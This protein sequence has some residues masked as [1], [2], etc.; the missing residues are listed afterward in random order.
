M[1]IYIIRTIGGKEEVIAEMIA[2]KAISEN[3]QIYSAFKIEELKGYVFVE[4]E[5][6][7]VMKVVKEIP[8]IRNV[9]K[10]TITLEELSKYIKKEEKEE[11]KLEVNDIVEI[12]G[13]PF[14]GLRG[15]VIKVDE[16]KKEVTV[17]LL[18]VAVSLP[19][20][21]SLELVRIVEKAKK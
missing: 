2:N 13:G 19:V 5:E 1:P 8:Y 4:G 20:T 7:D 10:Q 3:L 15:K 12:I 9:V 16:I 17:E 6:D 11:I 21:I 18:D 14:K